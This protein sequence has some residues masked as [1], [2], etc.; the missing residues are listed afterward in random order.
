MPIG[1]NADTFTITGAKLKVSGDVQVSGSIAYTTDATGFGG[2]TAQIDGETL[3]ITAGKLTGVTKIDRSTAANITAITHTNVSNNTT[4]HIA[5]KNTSDFKGDFVT[6]GTF[7]T[8]DTVKVNYTDEY[9]IG[10]GETGML[11]LRKVNGVLSLFIREMFSSTATNTDTKPFYIKDGTNYKYPLYKTTGENLTITPVAINGVSYYQP[12]GGYTTKTRPPKGLPELIVTP[13]GNLAIGNN[14]AGTTVNY[15]VWGVPASFDF[16]SIY[17]G[18]TKKA[19]FLLEN[20]EA[21]GSFTESG[22]TTGTSYE[23]YI[24]KTDTSESDTVSVTVL[25]NVTQYIAF[26]HGEFNA[27]DY[28]SAYSTVEAAATAG[29]VYS[30]TA[31][32]TEYTWGTLNSV[33]TSTTGQ[34]GYS[35]TPPNEITGADVLMVAGGGGNGTTGSNGGAG[36]GELV[37]LPNQ[38]ISAVQQTVIIGNGGEGAN[39]GQDTEFLSVSANGGGNTNIS[40]GSGGGIRRDRNGSIGLSVKTGNGYGNNGGNSNTTAWSGAGGG[41]GAGATG[42]NGGG[43]NNNNEYP[44]NGG[45]GLNE[46]TIDGTLYNFATVFGGAI[47]GEVISGESWFAGGGGGSINGGG[48]GTGGGTG[49]KGGGGRGEGPTTGSYTSYYTEPTSGMRHTGGGAGGDLGGTSINGGSGIVLV[50]F[51]GNVTTGKTIPKLTSIS[52]VSNAGSKTIAYTFNTQGTGIDK[53]TYKIGSGSEVTTASGVYTLS[54]TQADFGT[55]TMTHA[56]TVDSSGN[57]LGTK[58]GPYSITTKLS[59][60]AHISTPIL[61]F[62]NMGTTVTDSINNVP[63][64]NASGSFTY[65]T[66]NNAIINTGA[67][68]MKLDFTS[69]RTDRAT[70][71]SAFYEFYLP[72]NTDYGYAASLGGVH[73]TNSNNNDAI[74][75]YGHDSATPITHYYGNGTLAL[76]T[77][78]NYSNY[79][80]KWIK[81]GWVREASGNNFKVYVDG[82]YV[83][84]HTPSDG[85]LTGTG[86]LSYFY[87]FRHACYGNENN[88]TTDDTISFRNL[89]IYQ[90][91]FTDAQILEAFGT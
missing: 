61:L 37:F 51:T 20:G 59:S 2:V 85:S 89:E 36:A 70:A 45:D 60:L 49:G 83:H 42:T 67:A 16:G 3:N 29:H 9:V 44:G 79:Y 28:S 72:T 11:T 39:I 86:V 21:S 52:S 57:Q 26:H 24:D 71:I 87:L 5:L 78:Y 38:S 27:S 8:D 10:P 14:A 84:T 43:S 58:F 54:Y 48:N 35:W 17:K 18:T 34:T 55:T 81:L 25:N 65:D 6:I 12:S 15:D 80:G 68:R 4:I 47:Y 77:A 73:D 50:K 13:T 82:V 74:G 23:L 22:V 53:V 33:D 40:G 46:V 19:S 41:G 62:F 88:Y 56:Y 91:S 69:V 1:G 66:T 63:F 75:W 31:A 7:T 32:A 64:T 90:A 76:P 30:D